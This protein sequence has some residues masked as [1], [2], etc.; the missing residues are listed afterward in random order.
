MNCPSCGFVNARAARSC[1]GCGR[2]LRDSP[3]GLTMASREK[4][5]N[6]SLSLPIKG[7]APTG[8]VAPAPSIQL[9][10][11]RDDTVLRWGE[12]DTPL[13]P[14]IIAPGVPASVTV[15]VSPMRPG[16]A[17]TVEYRVNG[18]PVRQVIGIA[19]TSGRHAG[20]AR[21]FRAVLPGQP[22]GL[23]EFLPVLRFAGQSISPRLGESDAYPQYQVS[24]G[25][26]PVAAADSLGAGSVKLAR[27]PRWEWGSRYLWSATVIVRKEVVGDLPDG[28]RINWHLVEG[29]FA[30]PDHEGVVLL[31][32]ADYMRIR[33]DGIGI[34]NVTELLQTR[35]GARLYC[36]YGG[37]FDLGADGYE[38][39]L[40]GEFDPTPPFMVAPSYVTA[41]KG[42]AWL[43]RAQCV[44]LGRVD[45]KAMRL[46]YDVYAVSVGGANM[47]TDVGR[48]RPAV[49]TRGR[50]TTRTARHSGSMKDD[51]SF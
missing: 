22:G 36:T 21:L 20:N 8:Y 15:A 4:A 48:V 7:V 28:L 10:H 11:A 5:T 32:A 43:N 31:G 30:G 51:I 47:R 41:D 16:H 37:V 35:A 13:P 26:A 25:A 38:R 42:F 9:Q 14:T 39:A 3:G 34:V 2:A 19:E 40:L 17:V 6:A 45:M 12:A 33:R 18:G 46:E 49:R 27:E 44:G 29:S 23:V 50:E 24:S 1:G